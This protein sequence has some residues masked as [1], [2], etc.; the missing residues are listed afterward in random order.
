MT[1]RPLAVNQSLSASRVTSSRATVESNAAFWL[2]TRTCVSSILYDTCIGGVEAQVICKYTEQKWPKCRALEH[3]SIVRQRFRH[4]AAPSTVGDT[5]ALCVAFKIRAEPSSIDSKELKVVEHFR[6]ADNT[7]TSAQ[8][9]KAK[10]GNFCIVN[11]RE[12]VVRDADQR[13]SSRMVWTKSVL[14]IRKKMITGK[15]N[16]E[17]ALDDPLCDFGDNRHQ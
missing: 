4:H 7:K 3:S 9:S 11:R 17:L 2:L 10:K 15:I 12:N 8:I 14:T 1:F 13:G 6:M 5:D 16:V